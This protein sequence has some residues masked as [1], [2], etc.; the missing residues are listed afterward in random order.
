[1]LRNSLALEGSPP[2]DEVRIEL[3]WQSDQGAIRLV[4]VQDDRANRL[5]FVY[6]GS[7]RMG[8]VSIPAV[9]K[10][11]RP[12]ALS[13]E[14]RTLASAKLHK[15]YILHTDLQKQETVES[16]GRLPLNQVL[17]IDNPQRTDAE[18][19]PPSIVCT[20]ARHALAPRCPND[21][22][23]LLAEEMVADDEKP[24]L[25]CPA[26][27]SKFPLTEASLQ[28][29][30]AASVQCD[31][32]CGEC[33]FHDLDVH[34]CLRQAT[35]LNPLPGRVLVFKSWDLDLRDYLRWQQGVTAPQNREEVFTRLEE[36]R[37]YVRSTALSRAESNGENLDEA[38]QRLWDIVTLFVKILDAV[39]QLHQRRVAIL[40]LNPH[41]LA[42]SV[43]ATDLEVNITDLVLAHHASAPL[44][45]RQLQ[46]HAPLISPFAAP[47][48]HRPAFS[49]KAR[50][51]RRR[52]NHCELAVE[53]AYLPTGPFAES[54]FAVN[55]W[56]AVQHEALVRDRFLVESVQSVDG[57]WLVTGRL[58][59]ME[60][61]Q[62]ASAT[63]SSA[64]TQQAGQSHHGADIEAADVEVFHHKHCGPQADIFSLG[65]ILAYLLSPS[66]DGMTSFRK[67]L[68]DTPWDTALPAGEP[69]IAKNGPQA[70]VQALLARKSAVH[71][72]EFRAWEA[73]LE[74]FG[75]SRS[76]AQGLLGIVLRA[77][78]RGDANRF[79]LCDRSG[80][81]RA[82][83]QN[84][85]L[86][87]ERVCADLRG[88]AQA[89]LPEEAFVLGM[90]QQSYIENFRKCW[91]APG[92]A[93]AAI[94]P[95]KK[96]HEKLHHWLSRFD[97]ILASVQENVTQLHAML[98]TP[99]NSA[100]KSQAPL[101]S[102]GKDTCW[103][104]LAGAPTTLTRYCIATASAIY[105]LDGIFQDILAYREKA[106]EQL[107]T[108]GDRLDR[109]AGSE[110][111][112]DGKNKLLKDHGRQW[113]QKCGEWQT[114]FGFVLEPLKR[115]IQEIKSTLI[116]PWTESLEN[117]I[118]LNRLLHLQPAGSFAVSLAK[119]DSLLTM[120]P[121]AALQL[122]RKCH[123]GPVVEVTAAMAVLQYEEMRAAM[124]KIPAAPGSTRMQNQL[125]TIRGVGPPHFAMQSRAN[126]GHGQAGTTLELG[127]DDL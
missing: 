18:I 88:P 104:H 90:F 98:A 1:M 46:L 69:T 17:P 3:A 55:D 84:L 94:E 5:A 38:A 124:E 95:W 63:A 111:L 8:T 11:Q 116:I 79:Y 76:V 66:K 71:S 127:Q 47:E 58:D 53:E 109:R 41:G 85:R 96:Q 9:V 14:E 59:A 113:E 97:D 25:S 4:K 102:A 37:R 68:A 92:G 101:A 80:N 119:L 30:L 108:L 107:T 72:S 50:L 28:E 106:L 31:S 23:E 12:A 99:L 93:A 67:T 117:R 24:H 64:G 45:W 103:I 120:Q 20:K 43:Q 42:L 62:S 125:A 89:I 16:R 52:G 57:C 105:E 13:G 91:S 74:S 40:N 81:T 110:P 22:Q 51:A 15:E 2:T 29:I 126:S 114:N 48:C 75:P 35:F 26:C 6:R 100:C 82:A 33:P 70:L 73:N 49:I 61:N 115:Y 83:M 27:G 60:E 21:G 7:V 54:P 118:W 78:V 77:T 56:F 123:L 121:D 36:H 19:L 86:D 112:L 44:S 32:A 39:E 10:V 34:A 87:L 122:L 65:M